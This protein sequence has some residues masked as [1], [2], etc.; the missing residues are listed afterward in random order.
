VK[1][2]LMLGVNPKAKRE[3]NDFYATNPKALRL[4]LNKLKQDN[5]I[6]N[7]NIWEC[8][9]GQGHLSKE[10]LDNGY[11]VI[12]SDLIDRGYG[13][14]KDFLKCKDKFNGDILTNPPFKLAED[15]IEKSMNLLSKGNKLILFLKIQFIEG[16]RR[17]KLFKKYNIKYVYAHSSRQQCSKNADFEHLNATTQ[18][19]AWFIFEKGYVGD[20][21]LR[22]LKE[23]KGGRNSSHS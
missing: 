20:T 18:F 11:K 13:E 7:N 16:Q 5:I 21:I 23:E 17:N 4:L 12:S 3:E 14:V 9:C 8:S 6:L 2:G 15:F 19:Y 22:W 10:L 1:S